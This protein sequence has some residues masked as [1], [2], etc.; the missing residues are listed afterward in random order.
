MDRHL[1]TARGVVGAGHG[2]AVRKKEDECVCGDEQWIECRGNRGGRKMRRGELWN[3]LGNRTGRRG[4]LEES[5]DL[6][7][8]HAMRPSLRAFP[9]RP[10]TSFQEPPTPS[11]PSFSNRRYCAHVPRRSV[12]RTVLQ[13]RTAPHRRSVPL[14]NTINR[15]AASIIDPERTG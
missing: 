4:S 3:A 8:Q 10:L 14:A 15:V 12:D 5:G 13:T 1:Q 11:P 9:R 2:S 7:P 6:E